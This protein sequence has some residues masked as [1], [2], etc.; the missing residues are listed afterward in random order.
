MDIRVTQ[1]PFD[2]GAESNAFIA[3]GA[4]AG[5]AV[6]FTGLV[7]LPVSSARCPTIRSSH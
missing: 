4:A 6:T 7:P 5:A 3:R 2:P 1:S